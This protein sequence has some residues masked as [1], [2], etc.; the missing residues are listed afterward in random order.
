MNVNAVHRFGEYVVVEDRGQ[1]NKAV[2]LKYGN[3][4]FEISRGDSAT[5]ANW[6]R[7]KLCDVLNEIFKK[8]ADGEM[9]QIKARFLLELLGKEIK[10]GKTKL[11]KY[12][13]KRVVDNY[14]FV[15]PRQIK[16]SNKVGAPCTRPLRAVTVRTSRMPCR[17]WPTPNRSG[18]GLRPFQPVDH[19]VRV[20]VEVRE[21][22][23]A[24]AQKEGLE[25]GVPD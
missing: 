7:G 5:V 1:G 3:Q 14:V 20:R 10:V 19:V 25:S 15:S 17:F 8:V 24:P 18:R 11:S 9:E 13:H 4:S 16:L 6:R 23:E 21:V 12:T 2:L 22:D